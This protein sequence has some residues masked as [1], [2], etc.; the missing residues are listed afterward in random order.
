M[1]NAGR[2]HLLDAPHVALFPGL[3]IFWTVLALNFLGDGLVDALDPR[4]RGVGAVL[5]VTP[6]LSPVPARRG[7]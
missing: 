4:R 2:A 1:I 7:S 6:E 5:V 3:A